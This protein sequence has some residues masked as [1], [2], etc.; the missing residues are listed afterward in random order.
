LRVLGDAAAAEDIVQE[1]FLAVWRN[2]AGYDGA[3]GTF[4]AWLMASVRNRCIDVLRGPRR[5]LKLDDTIEATLDLTS[6][7]DVWET[8]VLH[9]RAQDVRRA[10]D[11]L[12]DDQRTTINLA[13]FGGLTHAQIAA[14]MRV[15]LGTVKGRMRLALEKLRAVLASGPGLDPVVEPS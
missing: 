7:D 4:R 12:P 13:Y 2:A 9:L 10:L 5:A 6:G 1:A 15:P 3:R 8:V 14:Q 11:S